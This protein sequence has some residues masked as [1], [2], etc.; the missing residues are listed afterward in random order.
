MS[1][2][3]HGSDDLLLVYDELRAWAETVTREAGLPF[4][5]VLD[6]T[7]L[8]RFQT[9]FA[10]SGGHDAAVAV[11]IE[12]C[13]GWVRVKHSGG[14]TMTE[15]DGSRGGLA[16]AVTHAAMVLAE[17]ANDDAERIG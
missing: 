14:T 9:V 5:L 2:A 7:S 15:W 16:E 1:G 8:Q 10:G 4:E 6:G 17:E 11:D 3:T 13:P 12:S